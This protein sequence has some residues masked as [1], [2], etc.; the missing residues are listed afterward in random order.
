MAENPSPIW[1]R[2]TRKA[3]RV[4][5]AISFWA[6]I[7][8]ALGLLPV[9]IPAFSSLPQYVLSA[10]L[11]AFIINYSFI[12]E[13]GWWSATLDVLYVYFFPFMLLGYL[14]KLLT[15]R[16]LKSFKT[17]A[18][19]RRPA[20]LTDKKIVALLRPRVRLMT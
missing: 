15:L 12:C 1:R 5:L 4:L 7:S 13:N 19:W 2:L 16:A 18:V 20:L 11:I 17:S 6:N 8:F 10:L 9:A 14:L 3:I